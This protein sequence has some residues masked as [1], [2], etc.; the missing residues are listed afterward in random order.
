MNVIARF[1]NQAA[2]AASSMWNALI[3]YAAILDDFSLFSIEQDTF[4]RFEEFY[5]LV[6]ELFKSVG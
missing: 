4:D 3:Y 6:A 2:N 1:R 5:D